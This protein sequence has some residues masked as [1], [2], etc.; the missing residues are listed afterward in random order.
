MNAKLAFF[1]VGLMMVVGTARAAITDV[2]FTQVNQAVVP[3]V[4]VNDVFVNVVGNIRT[5]AIILELTS[6]SIFQQVQGGGNT[7]PDEG[8]I[9]FVPALEFDTFVTMGGPTTQTS[10]AV[11]IAGGAV[12]IDPGATQKFDTSGLN[13]SWAP[14]TGVNVGNSD[15]FMTARITLSPDA[16]GTFRYWGSTEGEDTGTIS[17]RTFEILNGVIGGDTPPPGGEFASTPAG[18][19]T[20]V[21]DFGYGPNTRS[22]NLAV[23][24][25]GG[26]GTTVTV[27]DYLISGADAGLFS[28]PGFASL[29]LAAGAGDSNI[30][31]QFNGIGTPGI[32]NATLDLL[33][34]AGGV[35]GTYALTVHVPEPSTI[36]LAGL[37]LVGLVGFLRRRS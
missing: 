32:Y 19:G 6:G 35:L 26:A 30:E 23:R 9:G 33:D 4:V 11:L 10:S 2:K 34:G 25:V 29:P 3:D 28:L 16:V 1:A 5:Q 37:G 13:F 36:A 22:L 14:G 27:A 12:N 24:N 7:A 31:V 18:D 15:S 17:T 21:I 20:G 8:F